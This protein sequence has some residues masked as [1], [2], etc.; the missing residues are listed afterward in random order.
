MRC[1]MV[2]S[3]AV[4]TL[5]RLAVADIITGADAGAGPHVKVFSGQT[6][7]SETGSIDAYPGFMGGVRVATGDV[8]DDGIPDII[9]APGSGAGP[10]VKVFSG[11]G[12]AEIRSFFAYDPGFTGGVYVATGDFSE[13][14]A[15]IITGAGAG[16]GPHVKV[17]SGQSGAESR[18]FFA[19]DTGFTGGVRVAA[20]DVNGDGFADIITGAGSGAPGGHVKVFN[21]QTGFELSSFFAFDSSFD[22]GVFVAAGNV[23]G[24]SFDDIIVGADAGGGPHVKVFD[25]KTGDEISSFF[26]YDESFEGGVRVAGADVDGDGIAD[27]ITGAGPGGG[28]H[29]KVFSGRDGTL[30]ADFFADDRLSGGVFVAG[31][32]AVPEPSSAA[33]VA[34]A[35]LCTVIGYVVRFR[36]RRQS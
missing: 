19:Y 24:D 20:G 18:S 30:L 14:R 9:T 4:L 13:G 27:I 10:H 31:I 28:P 16:G 17:F 23:N 15:D 7:Q 35:G 36:R 12:G 8:N 6:G 33:L 26:A 25:G 34:T 1:F 3:L 21:G 29:V 22:G 32:A 2:A 11:Q 5:P